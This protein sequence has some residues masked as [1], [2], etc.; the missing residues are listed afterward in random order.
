MTTHELQAMG[1]APYLLLED[2]HSPLATPS[3]TPLSMPERGEPSRGLR[4]QGSRVLSVLRSLTN[5][6]T[7]S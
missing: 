7:A 6:S 2:E 3:H 1:S 5:G 4:R